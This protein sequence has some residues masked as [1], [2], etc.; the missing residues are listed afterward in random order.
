MFQG[1]LMQPSNPALTKRVLGHSSNCQHSEQTIFLLC[2][3]VCVKVIVFRTMDNRTV[4][5]CHALSG[6]KDAILRDVLKVGV[7]LG[8][9]AARSRE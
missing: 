6:R 3:C 8:N 9:R 7:G 4:A 1:P 2:V 5:A